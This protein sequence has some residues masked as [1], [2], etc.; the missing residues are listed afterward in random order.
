MG[1]LAIV[2]TG[3]RST[4]LGGQ[5]KPALRVGGATIA[6]RVIAAVRAAEPGAEV[7]VAGS[8]EGIPSDIRVV[9]EDPP[10]TGPLAGIAAALAATPEDPSRTVL[11]LGGDMP[12]VGAEL[13]R[14]L[15]GRAAGGVAAGRDETGRTQ[16]LCA[17]WPEAEIRARLESLGDVA[18]APLRRLYDGVEVA[19][20]D[21]PAGALRDVDTPEDLD[22]AR[23]DPADG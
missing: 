6:D 8:G 19:P 16:F 23:R 22:D 11:V 13:I 15:I 14:T 12:F 10:F 3:G 7:V 21:A 17:A 4:R 9:R 5:H 18:G 1:T 20:V 2:L